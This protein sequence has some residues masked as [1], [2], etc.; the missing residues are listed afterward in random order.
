M[1]T[2]K[3]TFSYPTGRRADVYNFLGGQHK[4]NPEKYTGTDFLLKAIEVPVMQAFVPSG[5]KKY[6]VEW[7]HLGTKIG[8]SGFIPDY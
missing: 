5:N 4:S 6:R 7:R 1:M 3:A 8:K 2:Q